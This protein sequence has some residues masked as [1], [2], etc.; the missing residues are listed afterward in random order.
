MFTLKSDFSSFDLRLL[1]KFSSLPLLKAGADLGRGRPPPLRDSTQR[2]PLC[3]FLKYPF[4]ATDPK[5][6]LK[7]PSAQIYTNFEGSVRA[8]KTRFF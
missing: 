7:D 2:V 4:L 1:Y 6:C 3:P 5:T 8:E